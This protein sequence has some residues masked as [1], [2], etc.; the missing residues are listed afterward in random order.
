MSTREVVYFTGVWDLLHTGHVRAL[1]AARALGDCLVVGVNTDA[2]TASRKP[3]RPIIPFAQRCE[4]LRALGCVDYVVPT[5]SSLNFDPI[6]SFEVT[7][8]AVGP[9]YGA[10]PEQRQALVE[11]LQRGIRVVY[12]PRTAGVSTSEIVERVKDA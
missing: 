6:D 1:Q 9:G 7:I 5:D 3:G 12:L 8:R 2:F 10:Y 11:M 4:V